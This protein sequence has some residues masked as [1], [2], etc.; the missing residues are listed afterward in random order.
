MCIL[1]AVHYFIGSFLPSSATYL[2]VPVLLHAR[3]SLL[4][5]RWAG[6]VSSGSNLGTLTDEDLTP[7]HQGLSSGDIALACQSSQSGL[8]EVPSLRQNDRVTTA[9]MTHLL[10]EPKG[11]NDY[12]AM[13]SYL[14]D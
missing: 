3:L 6:A 13:H 9:E 4:T 10:P 7:V 1:P 14:C 12:L 2:L 8:A 11:P 5:R